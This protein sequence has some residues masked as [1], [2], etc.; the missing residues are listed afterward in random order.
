MIEV[1]VIERADR[2]VRG[3]I[4]LDAGAITYAEFDGRGTER[5]SL[6]LSR[7]AA[8]RI[9]APRWYSLDRQPRLVLTLT[10]GSRW[11]LAVSEP[12]RWL[13]AILEATAPRSPQVLR[14]ST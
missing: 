1:G 4:T 11:T 3:L 8:L 9:A 12:E 13:T 14:R 7:V 10:D 6:A 2:S 5:G